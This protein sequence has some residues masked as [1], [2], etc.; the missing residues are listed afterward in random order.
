MAP[1]RQVHISRRNTIPGGGAQ[2]HLSQ[3]VASDFQQ[4][5]R[6]TQYHFPGGIAKWIKDEYLEPV[7]EV[8]K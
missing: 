5:G 6:G 8:V 3:S 1:L 2:C 7:F 4:P